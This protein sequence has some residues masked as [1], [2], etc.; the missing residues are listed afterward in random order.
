VS[1]LKRTMKSS[2]VSDFQPQSWQTSSNEAL[3][4]SL[5]GKDVQAGAIQFPPPFTYPIFGDDETIYG[6]KDLVIHLVFDSITYKPF[7][8]V[9]YSEKLNDAIDPQTD[10]IDKI[11]PFLPANDYILR[12]ELQWVD[13]FHSERESFNL[14]LLCEK[15]DEYKK[16]DKS[17]GIYRV[18]IGELIQ[19]DKDSPLIKFWLRIQIFT[20]LY[21]EA[22]TYLNLEDEPRWV[23]YLLFNE[24]DQTLIG[25][26]TTYSYWDYQGHES[27]DNKATKLKFNEKISQFLI[28]PP[29]QELGH[30]SS[31]YQSLY[32][33]WFK[34]DT[35]S[36]ITV[37]D[38]NEQFDDLRDRNDL[39]IL[40]STGFFEELK[41][42]C[43]DE[44]EVKFVSDEWIE[45]KRQEYKFE[46]RQFNRL[47]EMILLIEKK[48]M[49]FIR[50][51]KRRIWLKNYDSLCEL[52]DS[53][54]QYKAINDSYLLVKED[55]ERIIQACKF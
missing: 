44:Q 24:E 15:I 39:K 49:L 51:V 29:Y 36:C 22:A 6:Y 30:G 50:Q 17:Y 14:M 55:Y 12:D 47:I 34:Q 41:K 40:S 33:Y 38:P 16:E 5:I 1:I 25:F 37:E 20:L 18:P 26:V 45:L 31:L 28:M 46:K 54:Q 11:T 23:I 8:N 7:L 4:I 35:V 48:N 13:S 9:K 21:I 19:K 32:S 2:N 10:I 27:F 42:K 53:E 3:K 43:M 52:E